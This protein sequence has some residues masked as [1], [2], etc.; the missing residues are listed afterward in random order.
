MTLVSGQPQVPAFLLAITA[1]FIA[2][3]AQSAP[4]GG[5]RFVARAL[6]ATVLGIFLAGILLVPEAQLAAHGTRGTMSAA[7][8]YMDTVWPAEIPIR[9]ILPHFLDPDPFR[10]FIELSSYCGVLGLMLAIVG[11]STALRDRRVFFWCM[12]AVAGLVL[13]T[14]DTFGIARFTQYLPI[15]NLFRIPGR[16]AY[17][18][19]LAI[20][21]LA[22]FGTAIVVRKEM[23]SRVLAMTIGA[24]V[25]LCALAANALL[26]SHS[27]TIEFVRTVDPRAFT[28]RRN[29]EVWL[30]AALIVVSALALITSRLM[31][32]GVARIVLPALVLF[33][34][35]TFAWASYWNAA[36]TSVA[37]L[38]PTPLARLIAARMPGGR[39][40]FVP[41]ATEWG[42]P[43]N[44]NLVWGI[45]EAQ[46]YSNLGTRTVSDF[47]QLTPAATVTAISDTVLDLAD[48][49]FV[50][51]MKSTHAVD[52]PGLQSMLFAEPEHWRV[53]PFPGYDLFENRAPLP[54]FW[55]ASHAVST[56]SQDALAT[57]YGSR[58]GNEAPFPYRT[59]ALTE[60]PLA[61]GAPSPSNR[62]IVRS[63]NASSTALDVTCA[64][65]CLVV[66]SATAYPG[67]IA[68]IDRAPAR[69]ETVDV[70]LRGVVV[71]AGSHH[72]QLEFHPIVL[73]VGTIVTSLG[74]A[75]LFAILWF[76]LK[77]RRGALPFRTVLR[78]DG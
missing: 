26:H 24:L 41:G 28:A 33:D 20:A 4:G 14:G 11:A 46:I 6:G 76:C 65:P 62:V 69:L 38:K 19:T 34:M 12:V 17:E 29:P 78:A 18:F 67:W 43:T 8:Q 54:E 3:F 51:A 36:S 10:S 77:G 61:L 55:I 53:V 15:Y 75:G 47:L 2:A 68:S 73:T 71:P 21:L 44:V 9:L 63:Q 40:L 35:S 50:A 25:L 52:R 59:T 30:S 60:R 7:A 57:L 58:P 48:V 72:V 1:V 32:R 22:A 45:P 39:L 49:R 42:V 64:A 56:S 74:L 13:S 23:G 31:A 37:V 27:E 5:R 66:Q 70:A 16:H